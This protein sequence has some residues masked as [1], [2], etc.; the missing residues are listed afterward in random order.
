MDSTAIVDVKAMDNTG[1]NS[2]ER[3]VVDRS[4]NEPPSEVTFSEGNNLY[5]GTDQVFDTTGSTAVS[6]LGHSNQEVNKAIARQLSANV[7]SNS[8]LFTTNAATELANEIILG[9]GNLMSRAYFCSSG[10]SSP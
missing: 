8:M 3:H 2:A 4:F 5:F 1:L 6:Y 7:Y 9:T 10:M